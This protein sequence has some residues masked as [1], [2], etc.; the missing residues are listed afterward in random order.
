MEQ[1]YEEFEDVEEN[2][3]IYTDIHH[4]YVQLL[5]NFMEQQLCNRWAHLQRM[6]A[7]ES[8]IPHFYEKQVYRNV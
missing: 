7:I 5:E 3:F 6:H 2:K 8:S 1:Y 4:N